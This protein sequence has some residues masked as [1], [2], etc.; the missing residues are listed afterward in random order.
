MIH[1]E[2]RLLI[3]TYFASEGGNAISVQQN[4]D[5]PRQVHLLFSVVLYWVLLDNFYASVMWEQFRSCLSLKKIFRQ[6]LAQK[7]KMNKI[8]AEKNK[9]LPDTVIYKI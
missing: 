6:Y 7:K 4:K 1:F 8:S 9:F 2:T 3:I 5:I